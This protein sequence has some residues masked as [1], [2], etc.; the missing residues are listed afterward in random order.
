ME[1]K[2]KIKITSK[3]IKNKKDKTKKE[4]PNVIGNKKPSSFANRAGC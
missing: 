4:Y 3:K 1:I 2:I